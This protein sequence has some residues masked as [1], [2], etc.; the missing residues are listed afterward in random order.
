M[1]HDDY[2]HYP[3]SMYGCAACES[4][5]F[6]VDSLNPCL[7]CDIESSADLKEMIQSCG[8]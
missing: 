4:E 3:G 7:H 1:E 2:P 6:Y 8:E 5:C